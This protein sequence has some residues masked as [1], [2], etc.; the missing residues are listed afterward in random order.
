MSSLDESVDAPGGSLSSTMLLATY[1]LV[2]GG[3]VLR[4]LLPARTCEDCVVVRRWIDTG[5]RTYFAVRPLLPPRTN[6]VILG[7]LRL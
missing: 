1:D 7:G 3:F 2:V 4:C 6:C 5:L